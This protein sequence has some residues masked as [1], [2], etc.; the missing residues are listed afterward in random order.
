MNETIPTPAIKQ[1]LDGNQEGEATLS[2]FLEATVQSIQEDD[3]LS[4]RQFLNVALSGGFLGGFSLDRA[5]EV[6][7]KGVD[8]SPVVVGALIF[9]NYQ[10]RT[11]A[12]ATKSII[13]TFLAAALTEALVVTSR[14]IPGTINLATNI[15][16]K[17]VGLLSSL[18]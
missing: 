9:Y 1:E 11:D 18:S 6:F 16:A 5:L 8:W 13:L 2:P 3:R 17:V 14:D 4:A 7:N 12:G 10:Y 15:T